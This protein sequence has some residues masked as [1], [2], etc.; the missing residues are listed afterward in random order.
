VSARPLR[1]LALDLEGTLIS[2][3]VSLFPRPGLLRF[4]ES[5]AQIAPRVVVYTAVDEP[6]FRELARLLAREGEVPAWFAGLE[7]VPW[8]E[9]YKDLRLIP[10]ADPASTRLV[11]DLEEAV[12]PGQRE[13]WIPIAPYDP[14]RDD[15]ELS[16]VLEQLRA[17]P[18]SSG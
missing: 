8:S 11:D 10:G 16:R 1:T 9:R 6:R 3:A 7:H 15:R 17:P 13:Q 14:R 2:N 5:C 12:H 18:G 4:L